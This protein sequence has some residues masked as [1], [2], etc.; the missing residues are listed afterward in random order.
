MNHAKI[1]RQ[2]LGDQGPYTWYLFGLH[3]A[4]IVFIFPIIAV[5]VSV[6]SLIA[7]NALAVVVASPFIWTAAI[8]RFVGLVG[9]TVG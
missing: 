9:W 8:R 1:F 6:A 3:T 4:T 2:G 5:G 7:W